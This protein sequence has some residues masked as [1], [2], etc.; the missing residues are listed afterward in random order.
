M[1]SSAFTVLEHVGDN[2][3]SDSKVLTALRFVGYLVFVARIFV[4]LIIVLF[5]IFDI[6]KVVI[7]GQS[8]VFMK[9]IKRF[10]FRIVIGLL[11]FFL[12]P[13]IGW[14]TGT[15][16]TMDESNEVCVDCVLQP[17]ECSVPEDTE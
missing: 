10:G 16:G 5:G 2:V 14:F 6:Y 9:Q 4:P 17:F 1:L 3:C 15:F 7:A 8:D 13:I 11:V 12:P